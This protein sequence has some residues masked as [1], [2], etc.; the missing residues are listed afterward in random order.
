[1]TLC[2]QLMFLMRSRDTNISEADK[3][4]S[5]DPSLSHSFYESNLPTP[6]PPPPDPHLK[7]PQI[8]SEIRPKTKVT[9]NTASLLRTCYCPFTQN[10][11]QL[12]HFQGCFFFFFQIFDQSITISDLPISINAKIFQEN[13]IHS[14]YNVLSKKA[15]SRL[16]IPNKSLICLLLIKFQCQNSFMQLP[17]FFRKERLCKICFKINITSL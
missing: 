12:Q 1:M 5:S 17:R 10:G 16:I 3:K 8:V 14:N 4:N 7:Y 11:K 13:R 6:P 2:S 9:Y 15:K